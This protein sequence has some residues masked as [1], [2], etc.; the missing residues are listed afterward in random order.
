M[1]PPTV[2]RSAVELYAVCGN[3]TVTSDGQVRLQAERKL[4]NEE[5]MIRAERLLRDLRQDAFIEYR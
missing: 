5:M 4:L 2:F 1:T 3:R